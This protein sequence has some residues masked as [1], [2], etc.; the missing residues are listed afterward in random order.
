MSRKSGQ[1]IPC[2][3]ES[4]SFTGLFEVYVCSRSKQVRRRLTGYYIVASCL[5][6]YVQRS[7]SFICKCFKCG[8][9]HLVGWESIILK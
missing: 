5:A 2:V 1:K 6:E 7:D 9:K 4:G 8:W 3:N